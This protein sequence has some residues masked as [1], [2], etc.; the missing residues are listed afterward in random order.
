MILPCKSLI[1]GSASGQ[2]LFSDQ[3]LSFWGGVSPTGEIVDHHH[4]LRGKSLTG[5]IVAIPSGRGSCTGSGAIMELLVSGEGPAGFVFRE[6]EDILTLGVLVARTVFG[7]SIPMLRLDPGQFSSLC[8]YDNARISAGTLYLGQDAQSTSEVDLEGGVKSG[9][10]ELSKDDAAALEGKHGP[11]RQMA[12]EILVDFAKIQGAEKLIDVTQAHIDAC[13]YIGPAGLQFAQRFAALG[14]KFAVPTTLNAISIDRRR[15]NELGLTKE[16]AQPADDLAKAYMSMGAQISFTCAPYLLESAPQKG[17]QIGWAESNA[18]VFANSVLGARTQKYPDFLDVCIALTGRAPFSGCH[19]DQDR[20]PTLQVNLPPLGKVDDATFP[21]LGY[22]VGEIS[23]SEI[24]LVYGLE[25]TNPRVP[26][27]KAFGA[28]FATS[29]SAPMFHIRGITPESTLAGE[30]G[31]VSR[32][33]QVT[34][35]EIAAC[36]AALKTAQDP[37]VD[38]V[39]LGNPHFSVEE[40]ADLTYLCR[41]RVKHKAVSIVVTT[42]RAVQEQ[43]E[44]AGYL[45][46]LFEFGVDVITDTCWCMIDEPVIPKHVR[47]LMTNSAKYA[48]Y[49]PGMVKRGVHFGSLSQCV[50]AACFG[51]ISDG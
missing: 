12:M 37:S 41:G 20:M 8:C 46:E 47:N 43:A 36:K 28:G 50:D 11:A 3:A 30:A 15:W 10:I 51:K 23:G 24:P 31:T 16:A 39:S 26:D 48:H 9:K 42:S 5:C 7:L 34:I 45:Q 49:A 44:E 38:L 33:V 40:F 35:D 17:E 14:A 13:I 32:H 27:L 6:T 25:A 21:L 1:Q 29:S 2:L 19:R 22:L 18:V 4:S